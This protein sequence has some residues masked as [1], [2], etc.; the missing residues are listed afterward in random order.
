MD[1]AK[2]KQQGELA[3]LESQARI[4]DVEIRNNRQ[5]ELTVERE[6]SDN[7]KRYDLNLG[8]YSN[9]AED[10]EAFITQFEVVAQA[11]SSPEECILLSFKIFVR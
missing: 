11:Y 7:V 9:K 3:E 5:Y 8:V 6:G 10:H 2:L 4:Q 1:I